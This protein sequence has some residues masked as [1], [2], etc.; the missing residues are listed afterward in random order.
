MRAQGAGLK[1][2]DLILDTRCWLLIKRLDAGYLLKDK[3]NNL[4]LFLVI[5]FTTYLGVETGFYPGKRAQ[6]DSSIQHQ[7]VFLASHLTPHT[8]HLVPQA[9]NRFF[10]QAAPSQSE[11]WQGPAHK[12]PTVLQHLKTGRL[13]FRQQTVHGH[14]PSQSLTCHL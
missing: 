6:R 9:S 11:L 1:A 12:T 13:F 10:N 3:K 4:M 2:K 8:S 5:A 7:T 14:L